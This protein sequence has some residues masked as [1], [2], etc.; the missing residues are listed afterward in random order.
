MLRPRLR[1]GL[2]EPGPPGDEHLPRRTAT[3]KVYWLTV[4]TPRDADAARVDEV[5]NAAVKVAAQPWADQ[6]RIIDTVPVFTPGERYSDS[7]EVDGSETIVRESDGIHLNEAGSAIAADLVIRAAR[8]RILSTEPHR[9]QRVLRE[10]LLELLRAL[11]ALR[12]GAELLR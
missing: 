7:I 3:T 12:L 8:S 1:R 9:D 11:H 5:V 2:R 10:R 6:V 4:M